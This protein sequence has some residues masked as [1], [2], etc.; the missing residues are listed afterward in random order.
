MQST[1]IRAYALASTRYAV[2]VNTALEMCN[3]DKA[4][5]RAWRASLS[6]VTE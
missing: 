4:A 6:E 1:D 3:A 2:A 5:L